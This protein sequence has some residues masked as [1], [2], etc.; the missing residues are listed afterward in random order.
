MSYQFEI[1]KSNIDVYKIVLD[2]FQALSTLQNKFGIST[3][4]SE[5]IN[6]VNEILIPFIKSLEDDDFEVYS[7]LEPELV[8]ALAEAKKIKL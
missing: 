1:N 8:T 4:T 6:K 7:K 3:E 5:K 2:N